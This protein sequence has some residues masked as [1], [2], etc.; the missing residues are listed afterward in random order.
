MA[1][2][3]ALTVLPVLNEFE[4]VMMVG[5]APR[6]NPFLRG[7]ALWVH[8]WW[9]VVLAVI[10]VVPFTGWLSVVGSASAA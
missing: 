3:K 9:A 6:G 5:F 7:W 4:T 1:V 10:V 2:S 8:V